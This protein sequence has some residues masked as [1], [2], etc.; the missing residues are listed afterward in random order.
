MDQNSP[1]LGSAFFAEFTQ[2]ASKNEIEILT[3][4]SLFD[5]F[6]TEEAI[7]ITSH[8]DLAEKLKQFEQKHYLVLLENSPFRYQINY[9][10]KNGLRDILALDENRFKSIAL[11]CAQVL[12]QTAPLKSLELY[13]LS[14][15]TEAAT[16]HIALNVELFLLHSNFEVLSKWAPF[17][18]QILGGGLNR[19]K[20]VKAY[21]LLTSGKFESLKSTIR[22]IESALGSDDESLAIAQDLI[23]IKLYVHFS[24]GHFPK[25][26]EKCHEI[27]ESEKDLSKIRNGILLHRVF[28]TTFFYLQDVDGYSK[29]FS[30]LQQFVNANSPRL[31]LV[32]MNSFKAMSLF[33]SG[34][35]LEASEFALAACNLADE[36]E[37]EGAYYPFESSYILADTFLEFGEEAKSQDC[38]DKY[39]HQAIRT[40]QYSWI[41]AFYAKASLIKIQS[42]KA[43]QA[44]TLIRKGRELIEGPLFGSQI[45]FLLDGHELIVRLTLGDMERIKELLYKLN[46]HGN[47]KGVLTFKCTLEIMQNPGEA[48]AIMELI[49]I[50]TE[51]DIFRKELLLA[52]VYVGK[53]DQAMQHI[54]KAVELAI[55][56]GY[57][58][59]FLNLPMPVKELILDLCSSNPT[60]Y[61][62]NLARAIRNQTSLSAINSAAMD[63]PLTKQELIILRRL[64][65]GIPISQ[66]AKSLSIS[67][68]TIKTHLKSIYRKLSAES[69]QDAVVKARELALL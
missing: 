33:L 46:A 27:M 25:I 39:L 30:K 22:E 26:I 2:N 40:H 8:P 60:N 52:A 17:I 14:G 15:D 54:K 57:F 38:V 49:P 9:L 66:I 12:A 44:L 4:L 34:N 65:S 10:I 18:A 6:T 19:E 16:K 21:G 61:L 23:P 67:K 64:D 24:H 3:D 42:G 36:M 45:T 41:V 29:Y 5:S 63:K 35:Y 1:S 7:K 47:H 56:N 62:E 31:E 28:L 55:P 51:Q 32:N 58:R 43:D 11:K 68:N 53:R 48:E 20:L 59:A 37:V 69:R 50:Q 13:G